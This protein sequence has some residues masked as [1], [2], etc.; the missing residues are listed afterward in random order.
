MR[1]PRDFIVKPRKGKRYDNSRVIGG[2]EIVVSTSEEDH[3]FSNREAIVQEV[4]LGY[5]G[6][7]EKG[8]ILLVHHNVFKFYND[9]KGRQRSG[10]S[11]FK[12]D[13]FLIDNEQFFLYNK[14]G[15]WF[16]HDRYCFIKPIPVEESVIMKPCKSEPLMGVMK[17]PN[18]YLKSQGIKKGD[19]VSY[20]PFNEYAFNV[21][22]E[23]LYRL[24]DHQIT[25]VV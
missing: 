15:E 5:K 12:D 19:R 22:G 21:N 2:K 14:K 9:I 17:Y 8:D 10:R 13:I 18:D 16:T 24:Y 25:M 6:P 7:I 3:N 1:S 23:K 20:Q 4:P 11:F